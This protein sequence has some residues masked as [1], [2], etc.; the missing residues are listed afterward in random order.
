M[1]L[2]RLP[3]IVEALK[4]TR[5]AS[6]TVETLRWNVKERGYR[7]WFTDDHHDRYCDSHDAANACVVA[8]LERVQA[9]AR[10]V[11]V[12]EKG[13]LMVSEGDW[14]PYEGD[15]LNALYDAFR[16]HPKW[17]KEAP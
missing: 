17:F 6:L 10:S 4:V 3:E 16:T 12:C 11:K 1:N 14:F 7:W 13:V 9:N 8:M 5:P 2:E 15:L